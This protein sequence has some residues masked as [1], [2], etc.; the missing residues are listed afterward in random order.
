MRLFT[1][2]ILII[3]L[4]SCKN[5]T[6]PSYAQF[7][8]P[9]VLKEH[10]IDSLDQQFAQLS[11]TSEKQ[12]YLEE[13]YAQDQQA[14]FSN[15]EAELN[16]KLDSISFQK[17]LQN[18]YQ[19]DAINRYKI[20]AFL[21]KYDHPNPSDFSEKAVITPWLVIHHSDL[22]YREQFSS[23]MQ[24]AYDQGFIDVDRFSIYLGRTYEMKYGERFKMPSPFQPQEEID[25]LIQ[26]LG[27]NDEL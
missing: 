19:V 16:E 27:Y 23:E 7:D 22:S 18:T 1:T 8:D 12:E 11:S 14:R 3:V 6:E 24:S 21:E 20:R 15:R 17:A 5:T 9:T 13:I 26:L 10:V 4:S 25:S 2:I